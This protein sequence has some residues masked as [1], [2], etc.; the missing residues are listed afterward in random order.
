MP[1]YPHTSSALVELIF[2]RYPDLEPE[3]LDLESVPIHVHGPR[4]R[5]GHVL[6]MLYQMG[7]WDQGQSSK[8]GRWI[9]WA[10]AVLEMQGLLSNRES[11]NLARMDVRSCGE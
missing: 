5:A 9:G 6:W 4:Q 3:R 2:Q 11:R 7:E 10:L 1:Y 8:A